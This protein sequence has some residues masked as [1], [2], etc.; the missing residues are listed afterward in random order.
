ML[1][2]HKQPELGATSPGATQAWDTLGLLV[3]LPGQDSDC[4]RVMFCNQNLTLGLSFGL[5]FLM[6]GNGYT[7]WKKEKASTFEQS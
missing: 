2:L 1:E 6:P 5:W 4:V 3:T 7:G